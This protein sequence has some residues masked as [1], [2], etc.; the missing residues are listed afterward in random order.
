MQDPTTRRSGSSRGATKHSGR[1]SRATF[2]RWTTP[3][4]STSSMSRTSD[5][6]GNE[7]IAAPRQPGG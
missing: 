3:Y 5:G 1:A 2:A 4:R 7:P 6:H